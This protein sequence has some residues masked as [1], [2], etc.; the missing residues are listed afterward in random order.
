MRLRSLPG[1]TCAQVHTGHISRGMVKAGLCFVAK[2][3][4]SMVGGVSVCLCFALLLFVV[5]S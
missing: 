3:H 5:C 2:S 1:Q 4:Q